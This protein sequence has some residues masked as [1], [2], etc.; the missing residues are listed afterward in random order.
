MENNLEKAMSERTDE[1]LIKILT[2]EREEYQK[3]AIEFAEKEFKNRNIDKNRLQEIKETAIIEKAENDKI[4]SNIA[5]S[6]SRFINYVIDIIAWYILA[7]IFTVI[8]AFILPPRIFNSGFLVIIIVL[9]SF[10]TYFGIME[11]KFQ[12][13]IGKFITKTK[14]IREDGENPEVSDIL[15]RTFCRLIPLEQFSFLFFKIGLHDRLSKTK[16]IYDRNE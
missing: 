8:L 11:I 10:L 14:V 4:D 2:I 6:L 1:E 12:K 16:V 15:T 5:N 3:I 7:F 13:T 9:G